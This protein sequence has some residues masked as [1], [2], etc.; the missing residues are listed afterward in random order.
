MKSADRLR[1]HKSA[2]LLPNAATTGNLFAGFYAIIQSIAGNFELAVMA[3]LVGMIMDALD[4]R[5]ARLT[6]TQSSF[7]EQYDSMS[8]MVTFGLAPAMLAYYYLLHELGRW[9]WFAC[10]IYIACAAVRLARF[11]TN[12]GV[13]DSR[14]FQGLPSPS[15]AAIVGGF[16]WLLVDNK[17]PP[18]MLNAWLV[19]SIVIYAGLSMVSNAPFIS[20]KKMA[21][22]GNHSA[23]IWVLVTILLVAVILINPPV[24]IFA[25]FMCYAV[26]GWC[27]LYYRWTKVRKKRK[28]ML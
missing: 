5:I 19:F 16:V 22:Q 6:K 4:G 7:G 17:L 15:A 8:D 20:G 13:V 25:L 2:Y 23:Q 18:Y 24:M 10:F 12:I 26:S 3:L 27:V 1:Y 28:K 14:F 11:N 9:G 21:F